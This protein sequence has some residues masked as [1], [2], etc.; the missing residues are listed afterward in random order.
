MPVG[1]DVISEFEDMQTY[2]W[3]IVVNTVKTATGKQLLSEYDGDA[4][5]IFAKLHY[6]VKASQKA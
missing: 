2:V 6:N 5:T 1:D 4:Q 3:A